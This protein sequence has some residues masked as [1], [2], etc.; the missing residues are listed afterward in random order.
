MFF[1]KLRNYK[2]NITIYMAGKLI[3][4]NFATGTENSINIGNLPQGTYLL[5]LAGKNGVKFEVK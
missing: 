4:I 1:I 5:R 2:K 3:S